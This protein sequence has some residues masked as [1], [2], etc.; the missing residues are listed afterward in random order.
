MVVANLLKIEYCIFARQMI[1][2]VLKICYLYAIYLT[3][4]LKIPKIRFWIA[5]HFIEGKQLEANMETP[6]IIFRGIHFE[7]VRRTHIFILGKKRHIVLI[8]RSSITLNRRMVYMLYIIY[9]KRAS[10]ALYIVEKVLHRQTFVSLHF[11]PVA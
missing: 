7:E 11:V 3:M 6:R 8:I 2:R 4:Y 5:A 9:N 10:R 1:S